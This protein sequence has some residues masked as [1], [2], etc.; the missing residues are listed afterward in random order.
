MVK[1]MRNNIKTIFK[2]FL[3]NRCCS[4]LKSV[5]VSTMRC[6]LSQLQEDGQ[7]RLDPQ[8]VKM[9]QSIHELSQESGAI[10]AL[11][12]SSDEFYWHTHISYMVENEYT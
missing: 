8:M 2:L 11:S 3:D 6:K 5:D 10:I 12:H 9:K 4:C 7:E 1:L